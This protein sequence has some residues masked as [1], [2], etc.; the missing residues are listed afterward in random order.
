MFGN[1]PVHGFRSSICS[2]RSQNV[3]PRPTQTTKCE[4]K[5]SAKVWLPYPQLEHRAF[6]HN[7]L[8]L[9]TSVWLA[10]FVK[11]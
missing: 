3:N 1:P 7:T 10:F 9:S 5:R 6:M 11:S 8:F 4:L 2:K